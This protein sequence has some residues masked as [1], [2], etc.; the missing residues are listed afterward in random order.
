[1]MRSRIQQ[2]LAAAILLVVLVASAARADYL[3]LRRNANIRYD[4]S[5]DAAILAH[6]KPGDR[7]TILNDGQQRSGYYLIELA[8]GDEGWVYR[9]L[10][11]RYPGDLPAAEP[12]DGP[13]APSP[14]HNLFSI[15]PTPGLDADDTL[16]IG[17]WNIKWFGQR[18]P[19]EYAISVMADFVE[20]C[21][22]VALQELRG[23]HSRECIRALVEAV[24]ART[25]DG[26]RYR[27]SATTGYLSNP[28][29]DRNNYTESYAFIWNNDRVRPVK[30]PGLVDS[31]AINN[32]VFRQVPFVADFESRH[33]NGF[34][35]RVLTIHTVYNRKINGVR[36]AEI[37]WIRDWM[38][39][40][41]D[42]GETNLIAI[43]D[44]NANPP[45]QTSAHWFSELI[46]DS[47]DFRVLMYESLDA[48]E[49]PIRTT[50]PTKRLTD[51]A[52]P[53]IAASWP[54]YD[55]ILVTHT[56][57][58]ALSESQMTRE[59]GLLGV[60]E[61][62]MLPWWEEHGWSRSEIISAVSDHRPVWFKLRYDA[63][64]LDDDN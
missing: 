48:G 15:P 24:N 62:D 64:D 25:G 27:I 1:M 42:D 54:I 44:F 35:F 10:G 11:R 18:E 28:I 50:T 29:T 31:P 12:P 4:P 45:S 19:G 20:D 47:S 6:G 41:P 8:S 51:Y 49:V 36:R 2:I 43:G 46:P 3:E 17:S 9:T 61:F 13:I 52:D 56:T 32:P 14:A 39:T 37:D 59:M 38:I 58:D 30:K 55:H 33:P 57:S 7:F 26:Y 53:H 16:V 22:V 34:D 60:Y 40:L 5:S 23:A 21:D 63:E